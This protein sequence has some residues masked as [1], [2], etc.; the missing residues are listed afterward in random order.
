MSGE[1]RTTFPCVGWSNGYVMSTYEK[2]VAARGM[3]Y[4]KAL[5]VITDTNERHSI[6]IQE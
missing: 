3:T 6:R 5:L 4:W 2:D 1:A